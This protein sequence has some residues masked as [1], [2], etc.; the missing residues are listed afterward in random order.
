MV[1]VHG[2]I[3]ATLLFVGF[4]GALFLGSMFLPGRIVQGPVIA[5][6]S[7]PSYRLNGLLLF[8]VV[9]AGV[10]VVTAMPGVS[11]AGIYDVFWELFIVA[12]VFSI[13]LTLYLYANAK[14]K[15]MG[16][17]RGL[18]YGAELNPRWLNVDL[19]LFAYR[20]SLIGLA[21]LNGTF[22][23]VQYEKHGMVSNA[24]LA[25][26]TMTLF[27]LLSSFEYENGLLSMWDMIEERFGF[28]LIWGDFAL[29]PFFYCIPVYFLVDQTDP[30]PLHWIGALLVMYALGFW[31]FRGTNSQKNKFKT[32]P[33]ARI[34]GKK[35]ETI[36]GR[37][38][39]S[40]FWGIGRKLNYTG[41]IL[42]YLSWTMLNGF[43]SVWP[44]LLPLWLAGLLAHRAW[45]D[46][47]RCSAKY[48][49]LWKKYCAR[50]RFRMIPFVY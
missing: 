29:V 3:D 4:V 11:M 24:M 12:N 46:E 45:R 21:L 41:E 32:N 22:A 38:L 25:Y 43:D 14:D 30:M 40:G 16:L 49:E 18:W 26:Q 17:L 47:K 1:T 39:V 27:Y 10:V 13:A 15:S 9:I 19:K 34:W 42:I 50:V 8:L 7:Q 23:F 36:D 20:P 35:P 37:L 33:N 48:G 2:M 44:Y 31:M 5:D 28:M 6:G